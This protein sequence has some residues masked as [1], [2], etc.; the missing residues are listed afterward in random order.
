MKKDTIKNKVQRILLKGLL[1]HTI[2]FILY[3][4][5]EYHYNYYIQKNK[6]TIEKNGAEN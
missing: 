5:V 4:D 1:I 6:K 2:I 3:K